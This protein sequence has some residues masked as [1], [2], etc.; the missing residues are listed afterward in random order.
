[1]DNWNIF[2]KR[3]DIFLSHA[4]EDKETFVEKLYN[5]LT[6]A[7]YKVWYDKNELYWGD[8]LQQKI[9]EGL[10][11]SSY[12]IVV[13]SPSYFDKHK[14]WTFLEFNKI[15][16]TNNILPILHNINMQTIKDLHPQEHEQIKNWLAIS[17]EKGIDYIIQQAKKKI[18]DR[19]SEKG[20]DY[21]R[22]RDLLA[23]KNWKEAD[24]ETY[25]VMIKA[26]DKEEGHYFT[27][28]ELLNFPC[29][30]LRT[31]N[32]LWVKYSDGHFGF[33]VQRDIYLSVG[34]EVDGK[35]Y[36][37]AD[38]KFG[39]R[40]KWRANFL[41]IFPRSWIEYECVT[42]D[43]SSPVGHL[44]VQYLFFCSPQDFFGTYVY[45]SP[46][47]SSLLRDVYT[48]PSWPYDCVKGFSFSYLASRI[49]KCN[50]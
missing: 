42:F 40:V 46:S 49:V 18:G 41:F 39:D 25:R 32:R 16:T 11:K 7:Q 33:S 10:K 4:S 14:E 22:L 36:E 43:T 5:E 2:K 15:L 38:E 8:N 30:D 17:S 34:G 23:A 35:Y 27:Y 47:L 3:F 19:E 9:T 45:T 6:D 37:K 1:M 29:T 13:I 44:P 20:I 48:L 21:T 28:N 12:G 31:I 24:K 26:V 50:I